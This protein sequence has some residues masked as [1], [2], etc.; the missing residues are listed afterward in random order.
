VVLKETGGAGGDGR[1]AAE[2]YH[3][4]RVYPPPEA[5]EALEVHAAVPPHLGRDFEEGWA[6]RELS[7]RASAVL[8]RRC[9]R[10]AVHDFCGIAKDTLARELR[11]LERRHDADALGDLA[12]YVTRELLQAIR[13]VRRVGDVG[14]L[15]AASGDAVVP[16]TREEAGALLLLAR[17]LLAEWYQARGEREVRLADVLEAAAGKRAAE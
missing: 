11:E 9:A 5:P 3:E 10:G 16:A 2:T 6:I 17:T 1:G 4:G 7:P 13:A 15:M 8:A 12:P 14:A